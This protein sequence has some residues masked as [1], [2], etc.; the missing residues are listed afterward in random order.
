M[1]WNAGQFR[2]QFF[3][4]NDLLKPMAKIA[5]LGDVNIPFKPALPPCKRELRHFS[6]A[7][8]IS[9]Y[10]LKPA[11]TSAY[12]QQEGRQKVVATCAILQARA[13]SSLPRCKARRIEP[14]G[15]QTRPGRVQLSAVPRSYSA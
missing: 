10:R 3:D 9:C 4:L 13:S 8:K 1:L 12:A 2:R 14:H 15:Q 5:N 6:T 7:S 11:L